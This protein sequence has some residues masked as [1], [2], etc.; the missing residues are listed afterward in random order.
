MTDHGGGDSAPA[1]H[2]DGAAAWREGMIENGVLLG[3]RGQLFLAGGAHAVLRYA[4]GEVEVPA[5]SFLNFRSN[6][7]Q[8]AAWSKVREARYLHVIFPDKQSVLA[9]DYPLPPPICLGD[10]YLHSAAELAPD[11]LY[12]K[13]DLRQDTDGAFM[14]T[15]THLSDTGLARAAAAIARRFSNVS[16]PELTGRLRDAPI[17]MRDHCGD[18]GSK[19]QP[20]VTASEAFLTANW[21]LQGYTNGVVSR[22]N[23]VADIWFSPATQDAHRLLIFGDS[24]G[25]GL[26]RLLSSVFREVLFLRTQYFHVDIVDQMR[27]THIIT[28][29]VERYLTFIEPDRNRPSFHMY[30]FLGASEGTAPGKDFAEAF[31]AI[32]SYPR[33]P[34]Q[35][36]AA[37]IQR[38]HKAAHT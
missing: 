37:E 19:L 24:F 27:P 4:N 14:R 5:Q 20:R 10:K 38:N 21:P 1:S 17:E 2:R 9:E 26:A 22:N 6:L 31:S 15:D 34:Y 7:I 3:R 12:L 8:R 16:L 25:R 28:E 35:K 36:F 30:P 18:L 33:P 32:L 29:M 13:D 11:V 23:G